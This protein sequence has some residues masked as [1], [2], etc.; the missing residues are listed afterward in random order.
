MHHILPWVK[1]HH[2]KLGHYIAFL[3]ISLLSSML[4][5]LLALWMIARADW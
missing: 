3:L 1:T 4:P 5:V 2:S